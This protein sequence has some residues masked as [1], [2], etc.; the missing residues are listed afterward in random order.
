MHIN[1]NR[2]LREIKRLEIRVA[3]LQL[4]RGRCSFQNTGDVITSLIS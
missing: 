1:T 3:L 2:V 4:E